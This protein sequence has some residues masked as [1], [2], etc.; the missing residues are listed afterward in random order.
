MPFRG[1]PLVAWSVEQAIAARR[2]KRVVIST[3]DLAIAQAA[4]EA[5]CEVPFMR[6]PELATAQ[7]SSLDVVLHALDQLGDPDILVLLQPTSPLRTSSDI[8][9]CVDMCLDRGAPATVSVGPLAKPWGTLRRVLADGTL[10]S[11][12][13]PAGG[14]PGH[15][16]N[17]AV[18]AI[19][20]E[21]LRRLRTLTPPG[22]LAHVMPEARSVDIDTAQDLALALA[23]AG[24]AD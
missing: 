19:R 10:E 11:P 17:G 4:A 9:A 14:A 21:F 7:A 8:D 1:R 18:Y 6:P 3:N 13:E 15:A 2:V 5:G 24:G 12:P 20:P 16:L 23:L 22:T